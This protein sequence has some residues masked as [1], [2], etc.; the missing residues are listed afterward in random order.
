MLLSRTS[1]KSACSIP[2]TFGAP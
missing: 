1:V 2:P